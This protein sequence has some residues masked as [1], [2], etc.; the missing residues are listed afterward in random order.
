MYHRFFY[1]FIAPLASS[2]F[3]TISVSPSFFIPSTRSSLHII[4]HTGKKRSSVTLV[5]SLSITFSYSFLS[6]FHF[7]SI[8]FTFP[9]CF[10]HCSL[11]HSFFFHL[12]TNCL[13]LRLCHFSFLL[14]SCLQSYIPP[15]LHYLHPFPLF[16][17]YQH[18]HCL[19]FI[20]F[21][22]PHSLVTIPT[23][24][25]T[26]YSPS[27]PSESHLFATFTFFGTGESAPSRV[28]ALLR[29]VNVKQIT[30]RLPQVG[31]QPPHT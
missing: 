6:F 5:I 22:F 2:P 8:I 13:F 11:S 20:S 3:F 21:P 19:P 9:T 26:V 16:S 4:L 28:A 24:L 12:F 17:F 14:P 1:L 29:L 10:Y 30:E 25:G 15:P 7:F 31:Q 27:F 18:L 23:S